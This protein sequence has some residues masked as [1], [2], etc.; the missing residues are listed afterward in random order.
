MQ[1]RNIWALCKTLYG[2][3]REEPKAGEGRDR[4]D[5]RRGKYRKTQGSKRIK[6]GG[7]T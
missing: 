1:G 4:D 7:C 2:M 3:P 6:G 5:L